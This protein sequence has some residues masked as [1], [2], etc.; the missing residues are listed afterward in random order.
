M[1]NYGTAP[2]DQ[3][4]RFQTLPG[5]AVCK[6]E[7]IPT[8]PGSSYPTS[9]IDDHSMAYALAFID[10]K[11][12]DLGPGAVLLGLVTEIDILCYVG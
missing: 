4:C 7:L 10:K 8:M 2:V 9:K 1:Y 6:P 3:K 12:E 11:T 5:L